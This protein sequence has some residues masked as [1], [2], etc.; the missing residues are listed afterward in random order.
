MSIAL[1]IDLTLHGNIAL[2][3]PLIDVVQTWVSEHLEHEESRWW[4]PAL[5]VEP[6]YL[7]PI[8]AGM[9]DRG[10]VVTAG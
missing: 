10:L 4:G 9:A 7:G 5:A 2:I 1:D 8:V 6:R 3:T